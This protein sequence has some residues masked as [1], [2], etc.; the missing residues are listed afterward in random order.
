M[1]LSA[2]SGSWP[3]AST[4]NAQTHDN[5]SL[6]NPSTTAATRTASCLTS[7]LSTS[8]GETHCPVGL[9]QSS[10]RPMCHQNPLSSHRYK[11]P[12]RVQPSTKVCVVV[13]SR[14]QYREAAL[15]P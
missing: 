10:L 6:S 1:S 15:A 2:D 5:P 12:V 9:K 7:T 11:S 14:C 4:R 8:I 3:S 13:S